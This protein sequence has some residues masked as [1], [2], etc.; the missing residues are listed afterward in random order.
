MKTL[1]E[2]KDLSVSYFTYAGEVQSVRGISFQVQQGKTVA[3]VGESGCGK[4]VTA[5]SI[6]GLIEKPGKIDEKSRIIYDGEN[7][8]GYCEKEWNQFRGKK[9]S[10]IF[11]DALVSLNPTMNVGKQIMENLQ[12]HVSGMETSKEKMY[13]QAKEI[14]ELV[15]I[16]D[17]KQCMKKYPHELSGGMRQRVMIA[18]AMITH[19]ELLIADEP[20]T[21][22]DV[23]IQAQILELMKNLQEKMKMAIVMITHDLG[24]V[25]DI[26]D[27]IIVMYAGKIV[28]RGT[29]RDIFYRP[30]HPYT[31][32]LLR[33]VPRLDVSRKEPLISIE[34]TI[35]D[36]T[37]PP[38]GCAFC[39]RCPYAMNIC[40][41]Y[42]PDEIEISNG[43][44]AACW[45]M[46]ER[47]DRR[48]VPFGVGGNR[49]ER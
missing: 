1:L 31:W 33:S 12:N 32:A 42:M 17:A 19:P 41:E 34:G 26:A 4:S 11:Q 46:D 24:V 40:G 6:M 15:G 39:E 25:A 36:M 14:L 23:T 48:E 30:V 35:P 7:I 27:E 10:M 8:E 9:C 13:E 20:T 43:H 29:C 3:L 18:T 5:K 47:A 21:A 45:L 44:S 2:V 38:Q 28:E 22:L 37:N 16:P 49:N